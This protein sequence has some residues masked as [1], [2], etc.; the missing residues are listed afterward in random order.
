MQNLWNWAQDHPRLSGWLVLG[1]GMVL[2][3]LYSGRNAGLNLFQWS[4]LIISTLSVAALCV[5]ILTW[6][7]D[8]DDFEE[9]EQS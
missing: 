2:I 7:E 3:V 1:L 8:A 9:Q 5:W 6:D 4:M